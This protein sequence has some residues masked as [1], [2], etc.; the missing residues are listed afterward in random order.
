MNKIT[1]RILIL[2]FGICSLEEGVICG[3]EKNHTL[4]IPSSVYLIDLSRSHTAYIYI[5]M[6]W[7]GDWD[8]DLYLYREGW[9]F[10]GEDSYFKWAH[11]TLPGK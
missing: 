2:F 6:Y 3:D 1:M 7:S 4:S 10:F 8:L 11:D 9:D 5:E